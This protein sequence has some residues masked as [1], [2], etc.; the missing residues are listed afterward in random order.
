MNRTH[1][2]YGSETDE[3]ALVHTRSEIALPSTLGLL[4]V[5]LV[6]RNVGLDP[7]IPQY[8]PRSSCVEATI[9]IH[10]RTENL[11]M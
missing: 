9:R 8:L 4:S 1:F 2:L 7:A 3:P 5:A 10:Y 6:L 11:N